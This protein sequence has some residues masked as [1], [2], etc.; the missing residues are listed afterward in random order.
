MIG[1]YIRTGNTIEAF[2][3]KDKMI[4]EGI[5]PSVVTYST[6]ISGLCKQGDMEESMKLLDHM[7]E[8]GMGT[9][10]FA[11]SNLVRSYVKCGDIEKVS[12]LHNMM[13]IRCPSSVIISHEPMVLT[14][15]S[16]SK[17][18]PDDYYMSEAVS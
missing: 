6:L 3:L 18:M 11:Y 4:E 12:K 2:K 1:Q 5:A 16:D 10:L 9:D 13:Q 14:K 7:A 17:G 15:C 8:A